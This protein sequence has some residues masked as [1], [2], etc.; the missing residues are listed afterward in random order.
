MIR[1]NKHHKSI[2]TN[3]ILCAI[4]FY[5]LQ[6]F[7]F[8]ANAQDTIKDV[9]PEKFKFLKYEYNVIIND[10]VLFPFFESL[11]Q[12]KSTSNVVSVIHIGDS[13]IQ[14]DY[15]SGFVRMSLQRKFGNAGRGLIFPYKVART[16]EPYN[17]K[18]SSSSLS[19]ESHRCSINKGTLPIGISGI[20]LKTYDSTASIYIKT[21]NYPQLSYAFNKINVFYKLDILSF[22]HIVQDTAKTYSIELKSTIDSN[23]SE[24]SLPYY[25][26]E[27]IIQ[28]VKPD[29]ISKRFTEIYGIVLQNDSCGVI[30]H[31]VGVNGAQYSDY[32]KAELFATQSK[33][34]NPACIIISLGTNEAQSLKR[35]AEEMYNE[36]DSLITSL[37]ANNP[38]TTFILTTPPASYRRRKS[39]NYKLEMV[40]NTIKKYAEENKLAVWDL[41]NV[42]GTYKM[43]YYWRKRLLIRRDGL[44][45]TREAYEYQGKLLYNAIINSYNK[46]VRNRHP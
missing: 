6:I 45:F 37:K 42:S 29:T 13:H 16:N 41:Y 14:A 36:I 7:T 40:S 23:I 8:K 1:R 38:K 43:V 46:Y 17:Y 24:A 11:Y 25:T 33:Q 39:L 26:N 15:L 32:Y 20:T 34:L 28:N 22:Q 3:V 27:V 10:S 5:S 35:T 19:W 44:H 30:Y 18:T 4:I 12:I 9:I 31:T 2:F 21:Y